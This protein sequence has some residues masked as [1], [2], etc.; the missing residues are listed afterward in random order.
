MAAL[1]AAAADQLRILGAAAD[2]HE[3]AL[4]DRTRN[5]DR[6]L[7]ELEVAAGRGRVVGAAVE[8]LGA[9]LLAAHLHDV[10]AALGA[11]HAERHRPSRLASRIVAAREELAVAAALDDH[12]LA[13]LL[14]VVVGE[15][16][17]LE[18]AVSAV[19]ARVL[20]LRIVL[21]AEEEAVL[22]P[23]LEQLVALVA[24]LRTRKVG[25]LRLG[26]PALVLLGD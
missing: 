20:A 5:L 14:A 12:L 18:R 25:L 21:A 4:A 7:P 26:C 6:L 13:A 22:A 1:L 10:A 8:R 16:H 9:A 24:G 3:R 15:D 11:R 19:V 2:G 23:A 17:G